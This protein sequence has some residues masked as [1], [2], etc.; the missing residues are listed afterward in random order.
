[1]VEEKTDDIDNTLDQFSSFLYHI[2][3]LFST[4]R[5]TRNTSNTS[6]FLSLKDA[7]MEIP[8]I[9]IKTLDGEDTDAQREYR[10]FNF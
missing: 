5:S 3:H 2:F 1:M 9:P 10:K 8:P 7:S 4:T 6:K